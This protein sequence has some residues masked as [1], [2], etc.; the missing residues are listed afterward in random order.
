MG[1]IEI[2]KLFGLYYDKI[3]K[4]K[5]GSERYEFQLSEFEV[6]FLSFSQILQP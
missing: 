5:N 2:N 4:E 1:D 3:K 6:I